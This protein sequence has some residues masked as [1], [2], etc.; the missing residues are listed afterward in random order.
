ML[1]LVDTEGN[2]YSW[3]CQIFFFCGVWFWFKYHPL[4]FQGNKIS[5]HLELCYKKKW[6]FFTDLHPSQR[7]NTVEF[8]LSRLDWSGVHQSV[9]ELHKTEKMKNTRQSSD[10]WRKH[11]EKRDFISV[12]VSPER[13]RVAAWPS[14]TAS[15]ECPPSGTPVKTN[16]FVCLF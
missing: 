6:W 14:W 11:G 1:P 5:R 16:S 3:R 8:I 7:E 12:K 15:S 2:L 13:T 4:F 9:V 10:L